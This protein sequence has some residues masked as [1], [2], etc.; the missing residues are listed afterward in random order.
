MKKKIF[1]GVIATTAIALLT[2]LWN[3]LQSHK[4]VDF[5]TQIKPILNNK[6]ITC[7]GGVKQN[8]GFSL[9]FQEDVFAKTKSG[10]PAIIPGDAANSELIK[11]IKEDDPELRMPYEKP[12]LSKEEIELL[13]QWINEGA[14]WGKHWAYSLPDKVMVPSVTAEAG[15]SVDETSSFVQNDI[16]HF[17]LPRLESEELHPNPPADP[18]VIARRLALD[19]TGLPPDQ[20][21]FDAFTQGRISYETM[22]DTLLASPAY[23][24]KWASWWLDLARYADTKGYEKDQGRTMWRYR[25]WVIKAFN[26]DMPYDQFTV[27]QLAGDLLPNPSADQL[28]ATAFHR[29]TM[30]NDEGGTEDEEFRVAT[31]IDRTNTTFEVWE[32]TTM[33]CVQ[34]HSHPYDP[35][36]HED[37]YRAMA[38]F[39]NSRDEDTPTEDP[40]L[41]F[42][43]KEQQE[44]A[45]AVN[46]WVLQHGSEA[47][48][49]KYSDFISFMEPK[50]QAHNCTNFVNGELADT[51]WLALWDD[52]SCTLK[53][54]NTQGAGYMYMNYR[55]DIDGTRM[56]IRKND[57]HGEIL[58]QFNIDKTKTNIRKI[59][60]K[61]VNGN[62]NLYF[63]ANN[64][65]I[66]K[67]TSTSFITWVAFLEDMPGSD[68]NGYETAN[69]TFLDLLN[70]HTPELPIM[71]DN[72]PY[73]ARTTQVFE[74]GNWLAKGDTVKPGT[75]PVLNA[76][77][78]NWP[79]NRYGLSQW[80][81]SK[82]NPLTAR[83]LVNRVWD[84]LFGRGIVA[85][86]EDMGT[87][88]DP[89]THP[90]LLDWL[91][92]QFMNEDDWSI[93]A[94]IKEIV[95]SGTYRQSSENSPELY[96]RDPQNELYARGPRLRLT[97]EQIRDQALAVSGLLS[98][99]M[100]GP[101]VM[102][103][104]PEGIWQSVYSNEKWTESEGE[105]KYRRAVYTYLKRTSPYPSFITF[106]AGS[107]EVCTIKRTVTNTPL[108]ALV[109]L[110][111]P[112][113]M[114]AAYHL[115]KTMEDVDV[116]IGISKGYEKAT[117][118]K[119]DPEK[120]KALKELYDK[121]LIEFE[122]EENNGQNFLGIAEKSSPEL[123]ALTVVASAIMNL[124]E[125]LSKA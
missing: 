97:A 80:I 58:A 113:Y 106:D 31:V 93:K 4:R 61:K 22:V 57:A 115:A 20:E 12:K 49:R 90:E 24:E 65:L 18:N 54:V 44:K 56:T 59:P 75:P 96:Q 78:T 45:N 34:C 9:L 15:F 42:Y 19:L 94:L 92:L 110:N 101:G 30:N 46:R 51:K 86:I 116:E 38:F 6:C 63:E 109:T 47:L 95:M 64:D 1:T 119:I 71:V 37:Y 23:G 69:T 79:E 82:E 55:A 88:S 107:R 41:R 21:L 117:F 33:G 7:H 114:E 50:Y 39:N 77:D 28:I 91:A 66:P 43:N 122:Q 13:T 5:S 99:K 103:P 121:S 52:G 67:Q 27:E 100:Y 25:D 3:S 84:Q 16:D 2:V 14:E 76:W 125:F 118:S 112:V 104:Q 73:M 53:N 89:P 40:N 81:V 120:L 72:K 124:D 85:T 35:F 87:Q 17:I 48:A 36:R 10:K 8:G 83:T 105:D 60:F 102:P 11:R 70:D 29:N 32:S 68:Q 123:A 98:V 26:Q 108:Q 62:I 111:D 74:R